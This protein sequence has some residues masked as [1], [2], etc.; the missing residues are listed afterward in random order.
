MRFDKSKYLGLVTRDNN[1]WDGIGQKL[2]TPLL[3]NVT[4]DFSLYACMSSTYI[5]KSI[6]KN[7]T[8]MYTTPITLR[9]WGGSGYC[10]K[11]EL[12][13]ETQV[14]RNEEWKKF[15]L[16]IKPKSSTGHI[17]IEAFY[18]VPSLFPYNGNVLID[19]L[20]DFVPQKAN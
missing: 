6:F 3:A 4:Y 5:G 17:L 2:K 7:R 15:E 11:E 20:S 14:I 19:N 8:V 13:L 16:S 10:A 9:I 12:L 18:K 1:T